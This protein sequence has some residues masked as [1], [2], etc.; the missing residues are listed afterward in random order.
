V[1]SELRRGAQDWY[2]EDERTET[3]FD[4]TPK[5]KGDSHENYLNS[6]RIHL[7]PSPLLLA[8][9]SIGAVGSVRFRL[10]ACK[11]LSVYVFHLS[12]D[13]H[14]LRLETPFDILPA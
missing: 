3:I 8:A 13:S 11:L 6:S 5:L 7:A 2:G 10:S 12:S 14:N 1:S 9:N 4:I